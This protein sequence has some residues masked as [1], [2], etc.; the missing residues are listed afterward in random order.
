MPHPIWWSLTSIWCYIHGA[1][2]CNLRKSVFEGMTELEMNKGIVFVRENI[3][4][5]EKKES[6]RNYLF[7]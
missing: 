1:G 6:H 3:V 4:R 2:G 7:S 5:D